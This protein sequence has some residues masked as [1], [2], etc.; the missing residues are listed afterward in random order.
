MLDIELWLQRYQDELKAL[1]YSE[2]TIHS[3][4]LELRRFL[5]FL[6][7]Q[8]LTQI[9]GL[10]RQHLFTYRNSLC[11]QV[12]RRGKKI[13]AATQA[14][15]LNAV[16]AFV[17][18]LVRL[19][20]LLVD[21]SSGVELP[22]ISPGLPRVILSESETVQLLESPDVNGVIGLRDRATMEVLY[23]TGMRNSELC[24]LDLSDLDPAEKLVLVRFGKGGQARKVP[25]GEEAWIWVEEYLAHGRPQ[26]LQHAG[27]QALFLGRYGRRLAKADTTLLVAKWARR[28]GL[29]KR[30]TPHCL[31]HSCATHMLRRGASLRHLQVMLGHSNVT[32]TQIYTRVELSDLR[33]VL[34]RCHPRENPAP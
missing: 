26:L 6:E 21:V 22:R 18:A 20:Y 13:K 34:K 10:T 12:S 2:R 14:F 23:A 25:M 7:Q 31:R 19:D 27:E 29:E 1:N 11:Y 28:V 4:G 3:Y 17:R 32:T 9:S 5:R 15:R 16:L 24:F 30:V 33:K 8:G